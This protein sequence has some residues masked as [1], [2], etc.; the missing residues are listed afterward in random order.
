HL[1][2]PPRNGD[3]G[4]PSRRAQSVEEQQSPDDGYPALDPTLDGA[5][6]GFPRRLGGK[7]RIALRHQDGRGP[8]TRS[9]T[10][11]VSFGRLVDS[12]GSP[13][14]SSSGSDP[15]RMVECMAIPA[16]RS[17]LATASK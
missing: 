6:I 14:V 5:I 7:D 3:E 4:A 16:A 9:R 1:R 11:G 17:I 12:T 15:T 13:T 2:Y 10:R 8:H